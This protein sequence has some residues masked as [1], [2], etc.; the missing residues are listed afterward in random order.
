MQ[1][2]K[3][4]ESWLTKMKYCDDESYH[5]DY[6]YYLMIKTFAIALIFFCIIDFASIN[7]VAMPLYN[8]AHSELLELKLIS[9]EMAPGV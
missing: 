5:I 7:Y 6:W 4:K 2:Y 8:Q 1:T 3:P 9:A